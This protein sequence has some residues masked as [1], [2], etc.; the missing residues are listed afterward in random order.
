M[1]RGRSVVFVVLALA[2]GF[3]TFVVTILR[4]QS[5]PSFVFERGG[6]RERGRKGAWVEA[7]EG[8][9]VVRFS[10]GASFRATGGNVKVTETHLGGATLSLA[11]GRLEVDVPGGSYR[12]DAGPL[13]VAV[14]GQIAVGLEPD[15]ARVAVT[16][17]SAIAESSCAKEPVLLAAGETRTFRCD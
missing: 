2:L 17:G 15:G 1:P 8:G 10:D 5:P 7:G 14:T 11:S 4:S 3:T 13:R 6:D 16:R 9:L 12:V